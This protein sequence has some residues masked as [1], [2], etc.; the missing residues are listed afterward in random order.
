[1][2]LSS[3]LRDPRDP[4]RHFIQSQLPHVDAIRRDMRERAPTMIFAPPD[5]ERY[6]FSRIGWALDYRLRLYFAASSPFKTTA[7]RGAVDMAQ[8]PEIVK[9][10]AY[11]YDVMF[12]TS[13]GNLIWLPESERRLYVVDDSDALEELSEK[14]QREGLV[15]GVALIPCGFAAL[16]RAMIAEIELIAPLGRA[17]DVNAERRLCGLCYLLGHFESARFH[18]EAIESD[19]AIAR[20]A[21]MKDVDEQLALVPED[22]LEDVTAMSLR[23]AEAG[24]SLLGQNAIVDPHFPFGSEGWSVADADLVVG[25]TLIEIKTNRKLP[26]EIPFIYQLVGYLL[27]DADDGYG[28]TEVGWY[29][30]RY[31][32]LVTWPVSEFL[33]KLAG[34]SVDPAEMRDR[35]LSVEQW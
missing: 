14:L 15:G 16:G 23:F 21:N 35:V 28:I 18:V 4:L 24:G 30:A 17:L 1:M 25:S 11:V 22:A 27:A 19:R 33:E 32:A 7:L 13:S 29:L 10:T 2:G 8:R 3:R 5:I 6:L 12:N 9:E 20:I 34:S 31:G 26:T